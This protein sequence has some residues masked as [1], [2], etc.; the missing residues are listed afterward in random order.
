METNLVSMFK[1]GCLT[2]VI[3]VALVLLFGVFLCNH[4]DNSSDVVSVLGV[5]VSFG[6]TA[7]ETISKLKG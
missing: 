6:R 5:V 1:I 2:I 4:F 7:L 3:V